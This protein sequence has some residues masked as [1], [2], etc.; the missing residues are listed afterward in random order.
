MNSLILLALCYVFL[1]LNQVYVNVV[2]HMSPI[3]PL[4]VFVYFMPDSCR[5]LNAILAE[6]II[7]ILYVYVYRKFLKKILNHRTTL[8]KKMNFIHND[9]FNEKCHFMNNYS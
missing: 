7:L 8:T 4:Y 2:F 5:K 9:I 3:A 1:I 6:P